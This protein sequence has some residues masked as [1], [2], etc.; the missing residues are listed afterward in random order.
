M[1]PQLLPLSIP[2]PLLVLAAGALLLGWYLAGNELMRRRARRLARWCRDAATPFGGTLAI[3][4]LTTGSF[5]IEIQ[6][7]TRPLQSGSLTG[8]VESLDVAAIWFLNRLRG[9][10]DMILLQL[11]LDRRPIWGLEIFRDPSIL[12]ADARHRARE[13]GWQISNLG[14]H[15]LAAPDGEAPAEFAQALHTALADQSRNLVR[16]AVR[17]QGVHVSLAL[18]VPAP[19]RLPPASFYQLIRDVV[20]VTLAYT[21]PAG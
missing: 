2:G 16:L 19:A 17:R 4:W 1:T 14:E 6:N 21:T 9:R 10:R 5:Q 8:L 3:R 15:Q 11:T 12:A 7:P 18:N 13:E 20:D